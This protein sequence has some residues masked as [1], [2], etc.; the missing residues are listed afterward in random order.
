MATAIKLFELVNVSIGTPEV[1]AV[2]FNGLHA[3][4]HAIIKHLNIQEV[5][6]EIPEED[7]SFYKSPRGLLKTN[8]KVAAVSHQR[9]QKVPNAEPQLGALNGW[10]TGSDL[11]AKARLQGS[12][13]AIE[14]MWNM[15]QMQKRLEANEDGVSQAMKLLQELLREISTLRDSQRD[16]DCH[17][18]K[19]A[20]DMKQEEVVKELQKQLDEMEKKTAAIGDMDNL[21]RENQAI[22]QRMKDLEDK[23]NSYPFLEELGNLV[24]WETLQETLVRRPV[25]KDAQTAYLPSSEK[26][27]ILEGA[28]GTAVMMKSQSEFG[29]FPKNTSPETTGNTTLQTTTNIAQEPTLAGESTIHISDTEGELGQS[30]VSPGGN[31]ISSQ[32]DVANQKLNVDITSGKPGHRDSEDNVTFFSAASQCH[33]QSSD[34][35]R[36]DYSSPTRAEE[37]TNLPGLDPTSISD[38]PSPTTHC[39]TPNGIHTPSHRFADTVKVLRKIGV[40]SEEYAVL[41][42]RVEALER[43]KADRTELDL[44]QKTTDDLVGIMPDLQKLSSLHQDVQD[45]KV[46]LKKDCSDLGGIHE[47]PPSSHQSSIKDEE[48]QQDKSLQEYWEQMNKITNALSQDQQEHQ[49]HID[50]IYQ[51]LDNLEM[52]KMDKEHVDL[53]KAD[54]RALEGKVS[55]SQFDAT[56]EQLNNMMQDLLGRLSGQEQDWQRMLENINLEMQ[57][58]LDRMELDPLKNKLEERWRQIRQQLQDKAPQG[59]VDDAAAIIRKQLMTRFHCLS[60]DRPVDMMVPGPPVLSIPN[61]PGLPA[62]RSARPY[63]VYELDQIRQYNRR[64]PDDSDRLS[65]LTDVEHVP[66]IRSCGGS[67]TLTFTN[68][69]YARMQGVTPCPSQAEDVLKATLKEEIDILGSDGQIYHG[70]MDSYLPAIHAKYGKS[71]SP[72][73]LLQGSQKSLFAGDISRPPSRPS[74]AKSTS[75]YRRLALNA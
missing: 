25:V 54:L 22:Q 27:G 59:E 51:T 15:M 4:L 68:R 62:H 28:T 61:M 73:K 58:K 35:P 70:R 13:P 30:A 60:C 71:T 72:M 74:S 10:P 53:Q 6:V 20:E 33:G 34:S 26:Q 24:H 2:N 21:Q 37:T 5:T 11:I 8:D 1:G 29:Q 57:S 17:L 46:N 41:R 65:D 47:R 75:S 49:R 52:K 55:R 45:L 14:D 19:M 50:I 31:V 43:S 63:T 39:G 9:D 64:W 56:T 36:E 18:Q 32:P 69:R 42:G 44:L 48:V 3:L 66:S 23:L 7:N 38:S 67:H 16:L 40:M 12:T